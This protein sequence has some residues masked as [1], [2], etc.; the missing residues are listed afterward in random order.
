MIAHLKLPLHHVY[1]HF[2]LVIN[3]LGG[4]L[5]TLAALP[6]PGGILVHTP[7]IPGLLAIASVMSPTT[8]PG[9]RCI[10]WGLWRQP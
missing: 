5:I 8:K 6:H 4:L 2:L 9:V 10:V 1:R 3:L 7:G